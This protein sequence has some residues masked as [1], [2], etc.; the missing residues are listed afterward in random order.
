MILWGKIS[1]FS[2][3]MVLQ[4][5]A[6]YNKSG[7]LEIEDN[8]ERSTIY[9]N[10]GLVE[11]VSVPRSDHLLGAKLVKAGHL[12]QSDLRKIILTSVLRDNK[13]EFL[14]LTLMKSGMVDP[15][16]IAQTI[17][18]QAYENTLELS[19]WVD[20][21]FKFVVPRHP[22]VFPF[23]PQIN[24]QHLLLETSRR[25]DE[26]Q[27]PSKSKVGPPGNE[28]CESCSANCADSQKDKYLK[29]GICLWRNMPVIVR[30]AIF[31]PDKLRS[32]DVVDHMHDI[33]FL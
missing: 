26:G 8:E 11:A 9:L 24:V 25:L 22:V 6:S 19:N 28:L 2:V 32:A 10:Q 15:E 1:H 17:T 18:E 23:S 4:L 33:P 16:I 31:S 14:G 27:R 7:L 21:T 5:L 20:G 30:E 29:D 12:S 3:F 13:R